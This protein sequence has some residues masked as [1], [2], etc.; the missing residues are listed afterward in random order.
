[1]KINFQDVKKQIRGNEQAI[2]HYLLP[3]GRKEGHEYVAL[4]PTRPDKS[5]G[6]FRININTGR[7]GDFATDD[8]GGDLISL[9]AYVRNTNQLEAAQ[10]ISKLLGKESINEN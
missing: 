5:L 8:R 7:W 4:N 1:M 9:W 6:S 3:D 2:L 10:E